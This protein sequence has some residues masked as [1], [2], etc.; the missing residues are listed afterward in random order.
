MQPSLFSEYENIPLKDGELRYWPA[1][2][3]QSEADSLFKRLR[4][5]V[6]WEQSTINMYGKAVR[7]PR[8]NAW[9]G[10]KGCAYRYS[11]RLFQPLPWLACLEA[12]R[13]RLQQ[14]LSIP[15]NSVL[16]NCYRSGQDSVAWH[17]DD[18][19]ELGQN[20]HVASISLGATRAF[21]LRHRFDKAC[22]AHK[23]ELTSG[24]LL[25]MSGALQHNWEH[26]IP[27]TAKSVAERINLTFRYVI[28]QS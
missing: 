27:K 23:L 11:G 4:A 13:M 22:S 25:F 26:Q 24:S 7:I 20:P 3:N 18:E 12:I 14:E 19:P 17:S 15:F 2:L 28:P 21:H 16:V 5:S 1:W 9:Y 10:D 6:A 8:L